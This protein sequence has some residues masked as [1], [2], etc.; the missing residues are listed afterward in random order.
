VRQSE[1]ILS[2]W[3]EEEGDSVRNGSLRWVLMRTVVVLIIA[4]RKLSPFSTYPQVRY[5][6]IAPTALYWTQH[7]NPTLLFRP[8][9]TF[10]MLQNREKEMK[11]YTEETGMAENQRNGMDQLV[12]GGRTDGDILAENKCRRSSRRSLSM[13]SLRIYLTKRT[14]AGALTLQVYDVV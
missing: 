9:H 3:V 5:A 10:R 4:E 11:E 2:V 7:Q 14:D 6:N 8:H 12:R 13:H 1:D